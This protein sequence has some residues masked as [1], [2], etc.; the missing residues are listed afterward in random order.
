MQDPSRV[1]VVPYNNDWPLIFK[2]EAGR[3]QQ[4]L[5]YDLC[6][7]HHIG[8]TAIIGIRAKPVI[9]ILLVCRDIDSTSRINE[10]LQTLGYQTTKRSIIPHKSFFTW[11]QDENISFHCHLYERGD[12]QV[13]RHLNF[14]NYMLHHPNDAERYAELKLILATQFEYDRY[15]Y[16]SGKDKF[17]QHI[18]IKAKRWSEKK[19]SIP[20]TKPITENEVS[21]K[22]MRAIEANLNVH[23]TYFAQYLDPIELIRIPGYTLVNSGLADDTFNYVLDADFSTAEAEKKITEITDYF[24][25]KNLPFSW[26]LGPSDKPKDLATQLEKQGYQHTE[27][28][29]AMYLDLDTWDNK[30]VSIPELDIIRATDEKTLRDFGLVLASDRAAFEQ[31]FSWIAGIVSVD[32]PIEYYVGYVDGKPVTRGLSCYYAGVVGLHWLSTSPDQRR[33]G[34]GI[35]MQQFRLRRAKELGYHVAVLQASPEGYLLYRNLGYQVCGVFQ[36]FKLRLDMTR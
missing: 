15:A 11:R 18:D 17:V 8:S 1:I 21:E 31:Y 14:R 24:I 35:A 33:K 13:T 4:V 20:N 3:I 25:T 2:Q 34:Y 6:E 16:V 7:I 9:D 30:M 27:N 12:P 10:Q 28:N 36:E 22:L 19:L 26:W 29:T 32:D 23:M 5:A